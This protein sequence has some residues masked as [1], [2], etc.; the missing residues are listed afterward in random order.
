REAPFWVLVGATMPA[1]LVEVGYIS[2]SHDSKYLGKREY[3]KEI[4]NGVANGI[5]A[6]FLKN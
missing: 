2:N 5:D 6:D 3:Q 4:A 1:V